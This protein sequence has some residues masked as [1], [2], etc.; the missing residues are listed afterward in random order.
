MICIHLQTK[1]HLF[2]LKVRGNK[3]ILASLFIPWRSNASICNDLFC[4][5]LYN[6]CIMFYEQRFLRLCNQI[7]SQFI[8]L[9]GSEFSPLGFNEDIW[10]CPYYSSQCII[11]NWIK[12]ICTKI[13]FYLAGF[14]RIS[15]SRK[16]SNIFLNIFTN[17][18][19]IL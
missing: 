10:W 7:W 14:R 5:M 1:W 9:L 8:L 2:S 16:Y 11:T 19:K 17:F 15:Y 12:K 13:H 6:T 3:W 4:W 18:L